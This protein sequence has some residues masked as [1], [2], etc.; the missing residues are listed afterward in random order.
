LAEAGVRGTELTA[1]VCVL[2]GKKKALIFPRVQR[3][4]SWKHLQGISA[5]WKEAISD[6]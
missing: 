1:L 4:S 6:G 3:E 2:L 5:E